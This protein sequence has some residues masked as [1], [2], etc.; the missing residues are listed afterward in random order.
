MK[1][2][3][4]TQSLPR[5]LKPKRDAYGFT[6]RPQHLQRYKEYASIFKEEEEERSDKWSKFL[7]QFVDSRDSF[8]SEEEPCE[9]SPAETPK[10]NDSKEG[11]PLADTSTQNN[12]SPERETLVAH[13][14]DSSKVQ[15]WAK[16]RP[17]LRGIEDM[18]SYR[19]KKRQDIKLPSTTVT[20]NNLQSIQESANLEGVSDDEN[21]VD[22]EL[23]PKERLGNAANS[24]KDDISTADG[25]SAEYF[26]PWKEE[27]EFLV[28]GGVPKGL[29]GEAWQAFVGVKTRRIKGYYQELL[30]TEA[31]NGDGNK[32]V[33]ATLKWKKQ[34]E[35]DLPRTFPGHPALNENEENAFWSLVGIIDD[36]FDG[37]FSEDMIESQVDQ[38]VFEDLM[39]ERFPKLVNHLDYLGV[40]AMNFF[41]GLLL[42]MMPEENAFWSLVGIIDDY[43][44]GYFS[45]DMIESQVDQLV[46]EDLMRERFPKLV[47]HLDYLGVQVAWISAPWFLS[48]FVNMLPW[49]SGEASTFCFRRSFLNS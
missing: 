39:R 5:H 14:T 34:I 2:T 47:N 17:S 48:I 19:V 29:R 16:I 33:D 38:L 15:T 45:E 46:F 40:Q 24:S 4:N 43:F 7:E 12:S 11:E 27:L 22:E 23:E 35:K 37:Y 41:A 44:D 3:D 25:V 49:E 31:N 1:M 13:K 32:P 30:V 6:V 8:S 10:G 42:L 9:K 18:M 20:Q 28:R 36:Y 21:N 26:F